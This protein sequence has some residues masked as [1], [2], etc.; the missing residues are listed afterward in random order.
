M[1]KMIKERMFGFSIF[2]G[3]ADV[4]FYLPQTFLKISNVATRNNLWRDIY[5]HARDLVGK[6]VFE[7]R[8]DVI[9]VF[10]KHVAKVEEQMSQNTGGGYVGA[11]LKEGKTDASFRATVQTVYD[12][13]IDGFEDYQPGTSTF[14][15]PVSIVIRDPQNE[16]YGWIPAWFVRK[17]LKENAGR[18]SCR[19]ALR[20]PAKIIILPDCEK[21][22]LIKKH[23]DQIP[24]EVKIREFQ[25]A[26]RKKR[27]EQEINRK[28][29]AT[30][31]EKREADLAAA[32]KKEAEKKEKAKQKRREKLPR[33]ENVDVK[34]K[35]WV[36][37]SSFRS[38]EYEFDDV[39]LIQ[40]GKR[41]YILF[42]DGSE[43]FYA[44]KNVTIVDKHENSPSVRPAHRV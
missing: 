42:P 11:Q 20:W 43:S 9:T 10:M 12:Y 7:T 34:V 22:E 18:R 6:T 28:K 21:E 30:E 39:T 17:K 31:R 4:F 24:S 3:L 40:S 16:K 15:T 32:A 37:G 23:I 1:E 38:V 33:I 19:T 36:G 44:S 13:S 25:D 14:Y 2:G 8:E 29:E 26:E 27:A 35:S 5:N 41:T